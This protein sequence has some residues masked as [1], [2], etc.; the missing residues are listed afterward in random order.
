MDVLDCILL[1][2]LGAIVVSLFVIIYLK[3]TMG[4]CVSKAD[5]SGKTAIVTGANTGI[6]FYTALDFATRNARVILAC[7]NAGKAK[8]ACDQIR[9]ETGNENVTVGIIDLCSLTSVRKFAEEFL[10]VERRLD[11]LV[12]NASVLGLPKEITDEG[13]ESMFAANH[14]GPFLL[15]NLLLDLM[16][17][18]GRARIITVSS[19]VNKFGHIDFDNLCA[20]KSFDR[21]RIYN[22][23]K[24]ANV[25]FTKELARR[26]E[27][28][29]V[30]ANCLHPGTIRTDLLRNIP[31]FVQIPITLFGC[32]FFKSPDEG[33]Q[34]SIHCAVSEEMEGV[35]GR[36][37]CDCRDADKSVNRVA[38]DLGIAK[39]LW[40]ISEKYT[41]LK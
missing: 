41:D 23:S 6:G 2:I 16:K 31:S 26:M 13:L 19:L 15:T 5:L 8:V 20:E 35:S 21:F 3:V 18:T 22:D 33:A 10:K 30:T 4:R 28:T 27:G 40:E 12:N 9:Q 17:K 34:T 32:L 39:K 36:Y 1:T 24:L 37:Y 38:H 7:R 29:G 25:I 11:I 14:F